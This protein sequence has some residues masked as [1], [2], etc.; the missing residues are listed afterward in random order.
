[1]TAGVPSRSLRRIVHA[2]AAALAGGAL[3][4]TPAA[5]RVTLVDGQLPLVQLAGT[6]Y[7]L[8]RQHG[9]AL[10][11]QV[12][13]SVDRVLGYL[14][15]Y[16]K[17]PLIG[18]LAVN[19]W[20]DQPWRAS[21]PYVPP[22]Y[23]EELRGLADG[24]GVP[25]RALYRLHAVSDRT[26]TCANLAAWG[27]ATSGGRLIH[28]R[29]LDWMIGAGMQDFATVFV[30]RPAG[31]RAFINIGWAGFMGVL[32]GINDAGLS[33]GQ[34]GADTVDAT[35]RGEPMA[36][37]MRRVLEEAGSVDDA[38][39]L[40]AS[41]R[42]TVGVNYVIADAK[43]GRAVAME[44][45]AR[46]ARIFEAN[47]PA[48]Q[49]IAYARPIEDAVFRADTAIDP[50]I[51]GRQRAS[52]GDPARPGLEAPSGSAYETRYLG[53]AAGLQGRYGALDAAAAQAIARAI[54]PDSNVQSVV[55]AWPDLWV[56]NARGR[57]PAARTP[58]HHLDLS[59][60]LEKHGDGAIFPVGMTKEK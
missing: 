47:D 39:A 29:N 18:P 49:G 40:I 23:L 51:R 45:T 36:F 57:T 43:A 52:G 31:K 60:L 14:R 37:L 2:A 55:F 25:L 7:E 33:I 50:V 16:V 12:R 19:W 34:V 48:E 13:R 30:V 38:A 27:R 59:R 3:F 11:P 4:A 56:A 35:F 54:A 46:R 1:M 42:R 10:R 6:P 32:T 20:L 24:S 15:G 58:Y 9:E 5:A 26:A 53:Q 41:A 28:L 8:G 17:V 21:Q 44:T 22:A